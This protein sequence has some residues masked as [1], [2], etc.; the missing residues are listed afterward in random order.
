MK[1]RFGAESYRQFCCTSLPL[2]Q[3]MYDD[4]LIHKFAPKESDFFKMS[5]FKDYQESVEF[6]R[7]KGAFFCST[8]PVIIK[9]LLLENM[10]RESLVIGVLTFER[11]TTFF[12][13]AYNSD[14]IDRRNIEWESLLN[15]A[16][17]LS[18]EQYQKE[19]A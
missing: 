3:N 19:I 4:Y 9:L 17:Y 16:A 13:E 14:Y 11:W 8:L 15:V 10:L 1:W 12:K 5:F 7:F 6:Q 2:Y 18:S